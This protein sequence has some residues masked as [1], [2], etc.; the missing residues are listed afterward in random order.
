MLT[1]GSVPA[2]DVPDNCSLHD[3][4]LVPDLPCD[5]PGRDSKRCVSV[6]RCKSFRNPDDTSGMSKCLSA[7]LE[8]YVLNSYST[9]SRLFHVTLDDVSTPP[10]RLEIEHLTGNQL[11]RGRGGVMA[12]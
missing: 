1:V 9:K 4:L 6:Q 11:V 8:Q 12:V 10:E 3:E 7:H 2:S 5:L